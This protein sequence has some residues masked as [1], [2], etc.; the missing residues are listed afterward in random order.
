[1]WGVSLS[2]FCARGENL[3]CLVHGTY[4][5]FFCQWKKNSRATY[6]SVPCGRSWRFKVKM[7]AIFFFYFEIVI[8]RDHD[9]TGWT[10]QTKDFSG[11][12]P[13]NFLLFLF[14]ITQPVW[15]VKSVLRVITALT[16]F[17]SMPHMAASVSFISTWYV[18]DCLYFTTL[19]W[20]SG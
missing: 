19:A 5:Y 1:M 14:S 15:T 13:Y 17:Q 11:S 18:S 2:K 7:N 6:Q 20:S 4:P 10:A 8:V 12:L 9:F 16:V 3:G